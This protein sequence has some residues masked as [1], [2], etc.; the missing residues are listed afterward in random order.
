MTQVLA[1]LGKL[2]SGLGNAG[3][4]E[5]KLGEQRESSEGGV[6]ILHVR[7]PEFNS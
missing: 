7:G 2:E 3:Y 4:R 6:S 5:V 1:L